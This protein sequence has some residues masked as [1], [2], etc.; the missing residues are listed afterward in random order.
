MA[1]T[2]VDSSQL[3]RPAL[4]ASV[5]LLTKIVPPST[6]SSVLTAE[7]K[8]SKRER[9]LPAQFLVYYIIA[10]SIYMPYSL[11][12][13][14]RCVLEGLRALDSNLAIATKGAIS[15]ARTRLGWKA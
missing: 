12:E 13:V 3:P 10:L 2:S 15:R 7:G 4:L 6:V 5:G 11:R 8:L 1:R 9:A 14:L